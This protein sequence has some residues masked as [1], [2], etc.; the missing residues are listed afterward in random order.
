MHTTATLPQPPKTWF[1]NACGPLTIA[2]AAN[3]APP[4]MN[5]HPNMLKI[6]RPVMMRVGLLLYL[7][8][9]EGSR[10]TASN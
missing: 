10:V 8:A 6:T 4:T 5:P 2:L 7:P 3:N 9:G 1:E